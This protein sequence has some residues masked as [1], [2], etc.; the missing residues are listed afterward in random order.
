MKILNVSQGRINM[1]SL[2]GYVTADYQTLV[3]AFGEP[4]YTDPSGDEKVNTEWELCFE[5]EDN[6]ERNVV[7]ATIY[8]WKDYDGGARS[9]SGQAYEWHI[10]G[11]NID[12]K[13][14]VQ[15]ALGMS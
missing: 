14:A 9:R 3:E 5:V 12:A 10:G 13:F 2:Q 8:D 11:F 15:Q 4:H 6:G 7:Y 1:S